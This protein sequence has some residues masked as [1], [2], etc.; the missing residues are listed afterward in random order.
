MNIAKS[1]LRSGDMLHYSMQTPDGQ[2]MRG[3][4]VYHE[5]SAPE[6]LVFVNSFSNEKDNTIRAPFSTT[7][8]LKFKIH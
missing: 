7:G 6:K 2:E 4:F 8:R 5:G 3:K 1:G